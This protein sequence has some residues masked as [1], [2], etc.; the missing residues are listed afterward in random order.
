MNT[1]RVIRMLAGTFIIL[2]ILFFSRQS[3][4]S[5]DQPSWLWFTMFVGANLFQSGFT[6]WCLMEKLLL[7]LGVRPGS[8]CASCS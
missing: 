1:E 7:R 3:G 2:S 4:I 8:A 5:L 6:R